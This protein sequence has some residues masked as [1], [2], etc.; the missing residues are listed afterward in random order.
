MESVDWWQFSKILMMQQEQ[1]LF[2][3]LYA[4]TI[5]WYILMAAI[6]LHILRLA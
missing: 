2:G 3:P 5:P 1:L 4:P 6:R